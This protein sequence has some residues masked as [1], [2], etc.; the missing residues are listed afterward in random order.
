MR[1]VKIAILGMGT[2]GSGIYRLIEKEKKNIEH[3]EGISLEVA[4]VLAK[5]YSIEIPEELK[6]E[7]IEEIVADK[8]IQIVAEVMGG[9]HPAKE[10]IIRALSAGKTVVSANKELI[11]QH[12][13]E[14]EKA[15]A[16]EPGPYLREGRLPSWGEVAAEP[17]M[18]AP[19]AA[20][21]LIGPAR[22]L[23]SLLSRIVPQVVS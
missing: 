6:A 17:L 9:I 21:D 1:N 8:D 20:V 18:P 13:P 15:A 12:W 14:L 23:P 7:D 4:K 10:F 19:L 22:L 16:A 5:D 11:A 3:K 2:V